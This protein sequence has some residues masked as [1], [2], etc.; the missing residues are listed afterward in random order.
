MAKAAGVHSTPRRTK[1]SPSS[2][3]L[4][5]APGSELEVDEGQSP[6]D[7]FGN[8]EGGYLKLCAEWHL[9]RAQQRSNWA[10]QDLKS[11]WGYGSDDGELDLGPLGRMKDIEGMLE[12]WEPRTMAGV[13][14]LVEIGQAILVHAAVE[15]PEEY[16]GSGPVIEYLKNIR[17]AFISARGERQIAG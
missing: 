4:M 14:R 1:S 5:K 17:A 12:D 11:A 9:V 16:F 3:T 7:A 13:R 10:Q 8:M 15:G 6:F 2:A